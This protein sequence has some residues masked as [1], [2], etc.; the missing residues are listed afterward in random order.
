MLGC[1]LGLYGPVDLAFV[2]AAQQVVGRQVDQH[3]FVGIVQHVVRHRF[4]DAHAGDA[5][6]H[7]VQAFQVLHVDRGVD[8]DAGCQQLLDVLPAL[9]MARSGGIAVGQLVDQQHR[10]A[11]QQRGIEV[12]FG[13][14]CIRRGVGCGRVRCLCRAAV[15]RRDG[16]A[17]Q[18][19]EPA[20]LRQRFGASVRFDQPDHHI[21]LLLPQPPCRAQ[22]RVGLADTG[23]SAE[24]DLELAACGACLG[25][26]CA[27][28]QLVGV[29]SGR[30]GAHRGSLRAGFG[31]GCRVQGASG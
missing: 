29:G 25:S 24:K 4:P 26:L 15:R 2:Q 23:R 3:H 8:V 6:D 10:R 19:F 7:V 14:G 27:R 13:E 21:D 1:A 22:H 30:R 18:H 11:A 28:Q 12:E 16:A 9:G 20:D 31:A 17:R 5:A